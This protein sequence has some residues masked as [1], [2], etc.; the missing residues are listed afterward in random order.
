[1]SPTHEV[2]CGWVARRARG[3]DL[4]FAW[5]GNI[6][7]V[8]RGHVPDVRR[9]MRMGRASGAWAR[10]TACVVGA[11]RRS[12]QRPRRTTYRRTVGVGRV[13]PTYARAVVGNVPDARRACGSVARRARGPDLRSC[14]RGNIPDVGRGHVPDVRR[15]MRMGRASGAWARPTVC[16]VG[17]HP[18]RRSGRCP[19]RTTWHADGSRV[20]RVGPTYGRAVVG[21]IPDVG[22]GNVPDARRGVRIG[23]ASGAWAR[24]TARVVEATSPT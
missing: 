14:G 4:R 21:N 19:R 15:G 16:V 17:Q 5:S 18:R 1:M 10:P 2:A 7:D 11:R 8:G 23:R 22:R 20:G 9:G 24:P 3:P 12:G 6:P 13:G